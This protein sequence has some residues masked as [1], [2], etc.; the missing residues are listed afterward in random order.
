MNAV[1]IE[2]AISELALQ[3]FDPVEFPYSFLAAFGAKDNALKQLR[4]G[5]GNKS[6]VGGVLHRKH[7]HLAV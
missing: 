1:E 6:D 2:Q 5:D 3:P 7:I 4:S